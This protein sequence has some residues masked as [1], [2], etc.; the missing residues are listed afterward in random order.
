MKAIKA[1]ANLTALTED[2]IRM[3]EAMVI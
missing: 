2:L 1:D 3:E